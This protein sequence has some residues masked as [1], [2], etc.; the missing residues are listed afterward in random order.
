VQ[1]RA[2]GVSN[3]SPRQI[4]PLLRIETPAVLQLELHPLLQRR[5]VRG[6]HARHCTTTLLPRS[7]MRCVPH[8]ARSVLLARRRRQVRKFCQE[9]G[10]LLQA[11]SGAYKP[12][13]RDHPELTQLMRGTQLAEL[14]PHPAAILS[15]RWTLQAGAA[16]IPRSR[17]A[18]Y[19]GANLQVFWHGFRQLLPPSAMEAL[20]VV[21][22][23]YSLY[24]LHE[25]FVM[26]SIR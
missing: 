23:N 7:P 4:E 16:L 26:D 10:I 15:M 25:V 6:G 24:G 8:C 22:R 17:R 5:E 1:V 13:I 2:I 14:V 20:S 11:Y 18:A 12:D 9:H 19:V 3:F 21:D